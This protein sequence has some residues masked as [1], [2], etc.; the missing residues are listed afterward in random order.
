ME[1]MLS[2]DGSELLAKFANLCNIIVLKKTASPIVLKNR[3][4][5]KVLR[6]QKFMIITGD[7]DRLKTNTIGNTQKQLFVDHLLER[8]LTKPK[9]SFVDEALGRICFVSEIQYRTNDIYIGGNHYI[10]IKS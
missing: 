4:W 1:G 10:F 2:E 7:E 3:S 8:I 5:N 6:L 9:E